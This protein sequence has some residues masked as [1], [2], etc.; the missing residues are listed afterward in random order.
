MK[1]S[2]VLFTIP[3]RLPKIKYRKI[4]KYKYQL[5]EPY[6]F[7][8]GIK[9]QY[10][11]DLPF[12]HMT[13][14]GTLTAKKGYA[15]DGPSGISIDTKSFMRGSLVHDMLYQLEKLGF[16]PVGSRRKAD[17]LLRQICLEDGMGKFRAWY[18]WRSV[19]MFGGRYAKK[20]RK[21]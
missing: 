6:I 7:D 14:A 10:E 8:T 11:V 1:K 12:V 5:L 2:R 3:L 21:K 16:L 13:R 20:R 19:R 18:V 9:I 15:W 4:K 17:D